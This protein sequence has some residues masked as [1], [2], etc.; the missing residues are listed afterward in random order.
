MFASESETG[1]SLGAQRMKIHLPVQGN[2]FNPWSGKT[3]HA[4]GQLSPCAVVREPMS[5]NY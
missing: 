5:R 3:P 4:A 1:T 2:R